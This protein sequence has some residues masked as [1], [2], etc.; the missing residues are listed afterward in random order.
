MEAVRGPLQRV[1][2]IVDDEVSDSACVI[3]VVL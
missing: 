3:D 1:S 2:A